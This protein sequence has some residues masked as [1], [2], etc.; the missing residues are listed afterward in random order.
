[1]FSSFS[2]PMGN[3]GCPG[4]APGQWLERTATT[5]QHR[6]YCQRASGGAGQHVFSLQPLVNI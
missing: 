6:S 5:H 4:A 1:M 2:W 3:A